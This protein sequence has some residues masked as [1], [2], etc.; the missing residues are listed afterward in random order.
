MSAQRPRVLPPV[1]PESEP[2]PEPVVLP[3]DGKV[4]LGDGEWVKFNARPVTE[5]VFRLFDALELLQ[6]DRYNEALRVAERTIEARKVKVDEKLADFGVPG[7]RQFFAF[8]VA[9]VAALAIEASVKGP[10]GHE[11][12]GCDAE[13]LAKWPVNKVALAGKYALAL[14]D[15]LTSGI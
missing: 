13:A 15:T 2:E 7:A 10:D 1:A 8:S 11:I 3:A 12:T 14:R 9:A 4:D 6:Q 5:Q